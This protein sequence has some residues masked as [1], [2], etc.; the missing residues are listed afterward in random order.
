ME[1]MLEVVYI[2]QHGMKVGDKAADKLFPFGW[3]G[4]S[5]MNHIK[6]LAEAID[7][8]ITIVET[9]TWVKEMVEGVRD[10]R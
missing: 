10:A 1:V 3:F 9:E 8:G 2:R 6:A 7:K 4:Y 5:S